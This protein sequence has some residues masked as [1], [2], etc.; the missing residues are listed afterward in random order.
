MDLNRNYPFARDAP[1]G[2]TTGSNQRWGR[3]HAFLPDGP[4]ILQF[5]AEGYDSHFCTI[6]VASSSS[7][8]VDVSLIPLPE[9]GDNGP[10]GY[11]SP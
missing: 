7:Q 10:P 8:V 5:V 3:Y 6:L 2:G 4:H 9:N 11:P 1:C